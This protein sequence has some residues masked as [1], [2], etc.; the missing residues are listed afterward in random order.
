MKIFPNTSPEPASANSNPRFWITAA[1]IIAALL[2]GL[3]VALPIWETRS[4]NNG[5][6]DVVYGVLPALIGFVGLIVLCPAWFANLLLIPLCYLLYKRRTGGYLLSLVALA[7]AASAYMLP[8]IYGDNDE[9]IIM[10]RRV[11]FYF[12]LGS[13]LILALAHAL[14]AP[15]ARR[16][17]PMIRVGVVLVMV[18]GMVVL[19]VIYRVGAPPLETALKNPGDLTALT[20]TLAKNP[21]QTDKDAALWWAMKQDM[22]SAREP[23]KR[24]TLLIAAGA[25]PNKADDYGGTL[26][27]K[28]VRNETFLK[29]L[30]QAGADVN[31][32]DSQGR[33][34]L[35]LAR[36][37]GST[38]ACQKILVD[39]G[40]HPGDQK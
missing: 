36:Y 26:L 13:F 40:A 5:V 12:W 11:G 22:S 37:S 8:G 32:R 30:V 16:Q 23:S 9:D 29:F 7:V 33:T 15:S 39:A 17:S 1:I 34:I 14:L 10:G 19:E 35:D 18:L 20:A 6:W 25:N 38:P 2:W 24:L 27:M 4:N 31:A 21:S 3:S 28:T